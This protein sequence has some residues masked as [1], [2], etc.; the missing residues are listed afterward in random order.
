[1]VSRKT[2][3]RNGPTLNSALLAE[4]ARAQWLPDRR[5]ALP[6]W[7]LMPMEQMIVSGKT[8]KV[9][10]QAPYR[11]LLAWSEVAAPRTGRLLRFADRHCTCLAEQ[12]CC[13]PHGASMSE[14]GA[15]GSDPAKT[16]ARS[17]AARPVVKKATPVVAKMA[18]PPAKASPSPPAEAMAA[19]SAEA[20]KGAQ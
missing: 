7:R 16:V 13:V 3:R 4:A 14:L 6:S 20:S 18:P 10:V 12:S 19:P 2:C 9:H 17:K 1:M 11:P 15:W 5:V 8:P